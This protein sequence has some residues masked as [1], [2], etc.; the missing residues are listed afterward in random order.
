MA[1]IE[2][3]AG[4]TDPIFEVGYLKGESLD[5]KQIAHFGPSFKKA[6]REYAEGDKVFIILTH[7]G[8]VREVVDVNSSGERG[9]SAVRHDY[10]KAANMRFV[11]IRAYRAFSKGAVDWAM[12][13][14]A[15]ELEVSPRVVKRPTVTGDQNVFVSFEN[16]DRLPMADADAHD[17]GVILP[18]PSA[19]MLKEA[20]AVADRSKGAHA[21]GVSLENAVP[22]AEGRAAYHETT[23]AG[24]AA[25]FIRSAR[26]TAK[27]S[28]AD[29]AKRLDVAQSRVAELEK[30]SGS[31]GPTLGLLERI[32]D[33]CGRRLVLNIE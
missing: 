3:R 16:P 19:A 31:Q 21:I 13:I 29:L 17:V 12:P 26:Q 30:G 23:A 27:L 14:D 32:A 5:A 24:R 18:K 10:G 11:P 8:D 2:R 33:A 22:S 9:K 25:W 6:F 7:D 4:L 1:D 15:A 20:Q 28:Q